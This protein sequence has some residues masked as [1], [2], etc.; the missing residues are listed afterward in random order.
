MFCWFKKEKTG[1][2]IP[3]PDYI[4]NHAAWIRLE[5]QIDWYDTKSSKNQ[6]W[7]KS[8]RLTQT[9]L[10]VSIPILSH[11]EAAG[12]KWIISIAGATIAIL[13]SI[14]QMNQYVTLWVTY[15]ST[16]ERLKHE[17]FLFLSEAGPYRDLEQSTR[18]IILSERVEEH[19]STE[20]ANWFNETKNVAAATRKAGVHSEP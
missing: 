10:A 2:G 14:Q 11:V 9:V 15:R 3:I 20:H 1:P 7:H 8:L 5:D 12:L 6:F 17:K 16:A 4:K 18:L 13:E 19:V